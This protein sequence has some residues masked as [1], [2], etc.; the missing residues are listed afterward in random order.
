MPSDPLTMQEIN[1]HVGTQPAHTLSVS[2]VRAILRVT[3]LLTLLFTG[4]VPITLLWALR[5]DRTRG[6]AVRL[7]DVMIC[8]I[9]GL[10]IKVVGALDKERPLMLVANHAGY[11][12]VFAIG[13]I[14]P[15]SFTPKR[16]VRSWPVIG[17]L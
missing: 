9:V 1:L 17:F 13:S 15:V 4:I 11:L 5:L 12:D 7:F 14:A 8:L 3:G 10:R 6:R 16:E 2:R